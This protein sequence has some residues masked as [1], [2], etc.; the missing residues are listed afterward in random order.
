M[1]K[2]KTMVF[3]DTETTGLD[4]LRHELLEV[5]MVVRVDGQV[6]GD[7]QITFAV[8]IDPDRA[9][10][11]ALRV[12]RWHERQAEL[13]L[14]GVSDEFAGRLL[15]KYLSDAIVVGNN[16]QFDLRFVE[17]FLRTR[18]NEDPRAPWNYHPVDLKALAAGKLG[19]G[20]PPWSTGQIAREAG[21]PLPEDQ[22]A[23]MADARWNRDLYDSLFHYRKFA[24]KPESALWHRGG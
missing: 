4:A 5:G 6:G 18:T 16:P 19:L 22:H 14:M 12:N 21:V 23:A 2:T 20:E 15:H 1:S 10:P 11:D 17:H 7:K 13:A 9:D 3:L 24:P 8:G